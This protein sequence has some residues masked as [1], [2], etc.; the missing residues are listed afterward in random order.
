MDRCFSV[1]IEREDG[2]TE[3]VSLTGQT[4][5]SVYQQAKQLPGVRRVGKVAE[6]NGTAHNAGRAGPTTS[7]NNRPAASAAA[8]APG[9]TERASGYDPKVGFVLTGPRVVVH[10]RPSGGEQP[11]R[12]LQAPPEQ[13]G[14]PK[15]V[16]P[17][18]VVA[19]PQPVAPQP[20]VA[21]AKP[22][23]PVAK[24]AEAA[25]VRSGSRE[26]PKYRVMKSRRRDGLPFLLQR[27]TWRDAG[28]KRLFEAGWEKGFATREQ[29]EA[30][31]AWIAQNEHEMSDAGEA[32]EVDDDAGD[33]DATD[34]L[35][36]MD[37]QAA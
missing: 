21:A 37:C 6:L 11:F 26:E 27:G 22:A 23:A 10:A 16:P 18:P 32:L 1:V 30:H 4:P 19:A 35:A 25:P 33:A 2:R 28:G 9:R 7:S 31:L 34:E 8:P 13:Y 24:A 17:K 12:H 5:G 20:V 29:A 14:P 36:E 3:T 15:P